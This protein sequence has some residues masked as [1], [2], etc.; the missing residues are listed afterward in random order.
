MDDQGEDGARLSRRAMVAGLGVPL[1]GA[2]C[3]GAAHAQPLADPPVFRTG[4][5]Q[6]TMLEPQTALP[7]VTLTDLK[8]R[9]APLAA[10]RGRLMLINIWA[11][12]CAACQTDLPM[13]ERFHQ[14]R[15]D[16]AVAAVST[17]RVVARQSLEQYLAKLGVHSLPIYRDQAGALVSDTGGGTAPLRVTGMPITYLITPTG[18]IAGYIQGVSDWLSDEAQR[19]LEYYAAA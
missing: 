10:P 5:R 6:F 11:S 3:A 16:V 4:R 17:D 14:V 12:W 7:T 18:A 2:L 8:G 1:L 19:L 13:L 15:P 9:P